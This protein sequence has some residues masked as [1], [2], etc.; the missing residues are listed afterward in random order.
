MIMTMCDLYKKKIKKK[1]IKGFCDQ[2]P[3]DNV[4]FM[5]SYV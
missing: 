5:W 1:I 4:L 3:K 2:N